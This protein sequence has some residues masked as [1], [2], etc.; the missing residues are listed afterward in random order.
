MRSLQLLTIAAAAAVISGV[1]LFAEKEAPPS[2][3]MVDA[4]QKFLNSLS[5][6]L[7]QKANYGF[8]NPERLRW[9]F[10]P[11]QDKQ[12]NY[13]RKG[14]RFEELSDDQ[15]QAALELLKSGTSKT[16]Y[17]QAVTIMSLENILHD[18]EKNGAMV[19]NSGWYFVTVFG[20]PSKTGT[21]GWRIEGHHLSVNFTVDRGQISAA[22]PFFFG[23]NPAEVKGGPKDGLRTLPAVD[24]L[25]RELANSLQEDQRKAAWQGEKPFKEIEENTPAA[26]HEVLGITMEKLSEG[27]R[28]TLLKLLK[29][30]TDRMPAAIGEL[31]H[32]A[33]KQAG[34][35]QIHFAYT[36]T[37]ERGKPFTYRVYGPSFLVEFLNAQNDSA[38]NPANHIHSVWRHL[39]SDFGL[40]TS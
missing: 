32:N 30:Y 8:D 23:A 5:P 11:Q 2:A 20:E 3:R 40:K 34:R 16:G 39:P 17:E 10:T 4:G 22:T 28:D 6:E 14:V 26:T 25:A 13:T 9:F 36:G 21:W 18:L 15:K 33:V 31:E 35:E 37:P 24:D 12:K 38:G 7:K 29:A 19:R 1:A 27:Q